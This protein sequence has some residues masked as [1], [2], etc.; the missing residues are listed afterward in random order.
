LLTANVVVGAGCDLRFHTIKVFLK[1]GGNV[2]GE[3]DR[4]KFFFQT[5]EK[6]NRF[7]DLFLNPAENDAHNI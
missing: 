5:L 2:I 3:E 1:F 7:S 4:E 6:S